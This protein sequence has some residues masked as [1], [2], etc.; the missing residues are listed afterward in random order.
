[1]NNQVGLPRGLLR[2]ISQISL[3]QR[4]S[5][6]GTPHALMKLMVRSGCWAE[7]DRGT[8]IIRHCDFTIAARFG[9]AVRWYGRFVYVGLP[10]LLLSQKMWTARDLT[11]CDGRMRVVEKRRRRRSKIT[12]VVQK[13]G[14]LTKFV[15]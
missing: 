12:T 10:R 4:H 9:G 3:P 8:P 2:Q 13:L 15:R 1:M 6:P 14:L 7:E 11:L 5:A